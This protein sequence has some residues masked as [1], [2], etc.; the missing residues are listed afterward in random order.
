MKSQYSGTL[1][2]SVC[3]ICG[4]NLNHLSALKQEAHAEKCLHQ[5]RL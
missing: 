2:N 4:K 3:R 5:E 1:K